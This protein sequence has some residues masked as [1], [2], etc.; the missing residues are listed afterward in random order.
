MLSTDTVEKTKITAYI[1][2]MADELKVV[3]KSIA[4]VTK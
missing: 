1:T 3:E 2:D 4:E